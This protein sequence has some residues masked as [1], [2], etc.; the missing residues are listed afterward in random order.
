[1]QDVTFVT[2]NFQ[3]LQPYAFMP[4][5]QVP[6]SF[7]L[8][9]SCTKGNNCPFSHGQYT[10]SRVVCRHHTLGTCMYGDRCRNSHDILDVKADSGDQH[11]KYWKL[12]S[13]AKGNECRFIHEPVARPSASTTWRPQTTSM[14]FVDRKPTAEKILCI[15]WKSGRCS[16][17]ARC[18][19]LHDPVESAD[20]SPEKQRGQSLPSFGRRLGS[21]PGDRAEH[22]GQSTVRTRLCWSSH[23]FSN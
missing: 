4:K 14:A 20:V 3:V 23:S 19:Y 15:F 10:S 2:A 16:K 11:C 22:E 5:S 7:Y 12:G 18:E 9:N 13:C 17:G 6:C 8:T 21:R 1:M